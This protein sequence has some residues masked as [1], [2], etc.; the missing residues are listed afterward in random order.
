MFPNVKLFGLAMAHK[1]KKEKDETK[2]KL[3]AR[4]KKGKKNLFKNTA[5][6]SLSTS[7]Q[8]CWGEKKP[9]I[10][11]NKFNLML[12]CTF[13]AQGKQNKLSGSFAWQNKIKKTLIY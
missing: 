4:K 2:K 9:L 1:N 7:H 13:L 5:C 11:L 12:L 3:R 8:H 6:M 10:N